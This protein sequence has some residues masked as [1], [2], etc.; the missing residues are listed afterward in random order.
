[1]KEKFVQYFTRAL[2]E[3]DIDEIDR[4]IEFMTNH[5][6]KYA[7]VAREMGDDDFDRLEEAYQFGARKRGF[8]SDSERDRII[9]FTKS[10]EKAS[11]AY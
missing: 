10:L 1:M 9:R 5:R 4:L 2:K 7:A 11:Y 8:F 3:G 6:D